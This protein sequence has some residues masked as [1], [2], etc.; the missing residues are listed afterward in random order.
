MKFTAEAGSMDSKNYLRLKDKESVRGLFIGDPYV[1]RMHWVQNKGVLCSEDNMCSHCSI[2][3]KS[4]FRFRVNFMVNIAPEKY[5]AKIFEQG[6]TVYDAMRQLN[7]D[8]DL[9]KHLVKISRSGSGPSDTSYSVIPVPKGEIT[10]E[11]T[12]VLG[13]IKLHDLRHKVDSDKISTSTD[14]QVPN[15]DYVPEPAFDSDQEIPF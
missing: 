14:V 11:L 1:F 13:M 15:K 10:P 7:G 5:E 12:K 3:L 6:W 2:G 9:E 8:Y 4:S